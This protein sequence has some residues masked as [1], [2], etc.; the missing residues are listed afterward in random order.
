MPFNEVIKLGEFGN[1]LA[2]FL[3]HFL[4]LCRSTHAEYKSPRLPFF[5]LFEIAND[6][7]ALLKTTHQGCQMVLPK[8][9]IW[10][11]F[12]VPWNGKCW[13]IL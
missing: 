13:Y 5:A 8:I 2:E 1:I 9:R 10:V 4:S 7:R 12:E 3:K 11:N 6:V